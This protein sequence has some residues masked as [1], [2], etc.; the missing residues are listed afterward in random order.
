MCTR[1]RR[2]ARGTFFSVYWKT[3]RSTLE[4]K[5]PRSSTLCQSLATATR[6]KTKNPTKNPIWNGMMA[7]SLTFSG[8][9]T[10]SVQC[11]LLTSKS[12]PSIYWAREAGIRDALVSLSPLDWER[13][14]SRQLIEIYIECETLRLRESRDGCYSVIAHKALVETCLHLGVSPEKESLDKAAWIY[15]SGYPI[16]PPVHIFPMLPTP[17]PSRTHHRHSALSMGIS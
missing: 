4:V 15:P 16:T 9:R 17:Y 6:L 8:F 7:P 10:H 5:K 1:I 12:L 14:T 13:R 11:L 3:V 2:N